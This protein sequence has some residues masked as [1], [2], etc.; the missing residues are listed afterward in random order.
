MISVPSEEEE[1]SDSRVETGSGKVRQRDNRLGVVWTG[2]ENRR[3]ILRLEVKDLGTVIWRW[4]QKAVS[5]CM[6]PSQVWTFLCLG[7]ESDHLA[8]LAVRRRV[9]PIE[10]S[11]MGIEYISIGVVGLVLILGVLCGFSCPW[12]KFSVWYEIHSDGFNRM[13]SNDIP[14]SSIMEQHPYAYMDYQGMN[15]RNQVERKW[16]LGLQMKLVY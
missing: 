7:R 16:A 6:S 10:F 9:M 11:D 13:T 1:D 14:T 12:K 5:G 4:V 3:R 8:G 2:A 15:I